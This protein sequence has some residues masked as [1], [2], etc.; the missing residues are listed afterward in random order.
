MNNSFN[1]MS[2]FNLAQPGGGENPWNDASKSP[3]AFSLRCSAHRSLLT[4]LIVSAT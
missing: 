1:A 4:P 2:G 3:G